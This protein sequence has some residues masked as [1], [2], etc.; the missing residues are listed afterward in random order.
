LAALLDASRYEVGDTY[1]IHL[2]NKNH[3]YEESDHRHNFQMG[4]VTAI[5]GGRTQT[6]DIQDYGR[7]GSGNVNDGHWVKP[8]KVDHVKK[9]SVVVAKT[10]VVPHGSKDPCA[11]VWVPTTA[12]AGP[13][14]LL[15]HGRNCLEL[16][17][18]P[19]ISLIELLTEVSVMHSLDAEA[20]NKRAAEIYAL[21]RPLRQGEAKIDYFVSHSRSDDDEGKFRALQQVAES[22]KADRGRFPT[23]WL[24][25]FCFGK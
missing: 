11:L 14:E 12:H 23:F 22:F 17:N 3:Q 25:I 18:W 2:D 19:T 13:A 10:L 8:N 9:T 4:T 24:D 1:W 20:R 15:K 5:G 16:L 7:D 21:S 6:S